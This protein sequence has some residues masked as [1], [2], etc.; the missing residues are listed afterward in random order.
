MMKIDNF[1]NLHITKCES[2]DITVKAED[3]N[4]QAYAFQPGDALTFSISEDYDNGKYYREKIVEITEETESVAFSFDSDFT[5]I[6]DKNDAISLHYEV[7]LE[8][9]AGKTQTIIGKDDEYDYLF[10]IYP[11]FIKEGE[12]L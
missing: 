8:T 2:F 11:S 4:G 1:N 9:A 12:E 6:E 10:V 3:E 5:N 7:K